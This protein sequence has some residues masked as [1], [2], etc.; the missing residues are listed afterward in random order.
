MIDSRVWE[1]IL[2]KS[3]TTYGLICEASNIEK[4]IM[5]LYEEAKSWLLRE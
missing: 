1:H 2:S 3:T 4:R 5:I